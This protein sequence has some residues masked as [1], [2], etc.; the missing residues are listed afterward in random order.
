MIYKSVADLA[1]TISRSISRLPADIDMVIGIPR[2]GMLA[3]S[4]IALQRNCRLLDIGSFCANAPITTGTT[5]SASGE[6]IHRAWDARHVLVVDDSAFSGHSMEH[7]RAQVT[8]SGYRGRSSFGVV[9]ASSTARKSA[10]YFME[11]TSMPRVF[12][13]N[14]LHRKEAEHYCVDI[15]GVLCHDPTEAENDDGP[16]YLKFLRETEQL[17]FSSYRIG[18]L[19]TSRLE[20]YRAPT[21]EWLKR[22]GV[23]Y[24]V[25]HMLDLPSAA[26]RRRQRLH[27]LFKASVY[28][29][30]QQSILFIESE[31]SQA[32]EIAQRS[33]KPV[34]DYGVQVLRQSPLTSRIPALVERRSRKLVQ[35]FRGTLDST[36]RRWL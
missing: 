30:E 13:W 16:R 24:G 15:D 32:I 35:R 14:V 31:S 7:A 20:K 12:E 17:A 33:G 34:L 21:E 6:V 1:S 25:L 3:A 4:L 5:R 8:A 36:L 18:H 2:S 9:Y 29:S 19:V 10:D 26:E 22:K 23:E 28:R 11:E 27:A